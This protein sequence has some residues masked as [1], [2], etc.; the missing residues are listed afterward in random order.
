MEKKL[1]LTEK[2]LTNFEKIENPWEI[3]FQDM[4]LVLKN[5]KSIVDNVNGVIRHSRTTALM[6]ASGAG[7]TSLLTLLNGK[8][9]YGDIKGKVLINNQ[10]VNSLSEYAAYI[11]F[12]P[13]EDIMYEDLTVEQNLRY[14]MLLFHKE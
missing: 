3:T 13:Q 5:G 9:H 6:G 14:Q 1:L 8:A 2:R 12:V 7:K 4:S 11:G 10:A